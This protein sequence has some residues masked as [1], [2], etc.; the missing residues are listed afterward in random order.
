MPTATMT[1]KGQITVPKE[2]R[3]DLKLVAGSRVMFV[4]LPNGRYTI[5]P[6]TGSIMD[7]AGVLYNP[8]QPPIS[9]EQMNDDIADAAAEHVMRSMQR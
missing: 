7:L 4:K 1:S 6:K 8:D 9:I 3:D 2:V 5:V